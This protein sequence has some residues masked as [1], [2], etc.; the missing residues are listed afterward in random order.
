MKVIVDRRFLH[1]SF[2]Y[3]FT[4]LTNAASEIMNFICILE[5]YYRFNY[6]YI[7]I[8]IMQQTFSECLPL[9]HFLI[10]NLYFISIYV[11]IFIFYYYVSG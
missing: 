9:L 8:Y 3:I 5:I 1:E 11:Y 7:Y 10:Y 4:Q 6:I 2:L